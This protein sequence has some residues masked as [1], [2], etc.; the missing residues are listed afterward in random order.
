MYLGVEEMS[1]Q[2]LG[3]QSLTSAPFD[4]GVIVRSVKNKTIQ[5]RVRQL[6][7]SQIP[8]ISTDL[9]FNFKRL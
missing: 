2:S 3:P 1:R 6:L 4:N 8:L 9:P 5:I 7:S